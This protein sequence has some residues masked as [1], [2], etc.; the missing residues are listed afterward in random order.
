MQ[1]KLVM[2]MRFVI[3]LLISQKTNKKTK[4]ENPLKQNSILPTLYNAYKFYVFVCVSVL[5]YGPFSVR[6]IGSAIFGASF[7]L[8]AR[9][10]LP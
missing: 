4:Q 6:L 9:V 1:Y 8:A 3:F 7:N 2:L 10:G 5:D